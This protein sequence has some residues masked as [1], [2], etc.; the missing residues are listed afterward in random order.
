MGNKLVKILDCTLRDGGYCN[1]WDFGFDNTKYIIQKLVNAKIDIVECGFLSQKGNDVPGRTVFSNV[2]SLK[3]Y[4]PEHKNGSEYVCMINYGEFNIAEL[5]EN[6]GTIDGV[7]VAFHKDDMPGA[8]AMCAQIMEKGYDAYVQPMVTLSYSDFELLELV[9]A[10]NKMKAKALYIVDSF[11]VVR[12]KDL[13]RMYYLIDHNLHE[14][15]AIGYHSHNNM[16]LAYSNAQALVEIRT[17]RLNIIDSS[18]FGMGRGAGNL[19]TELFVEYVNDALQTDYKVFPLLQVIDNVLN[20]IYYSSYWGY[21]L[22]HYLSSKNNCHPNY[23][24]YLSDKNTLSIEAISEILGQIPMKNKINFSKTIIET[25]YLNYQQTFF[26]DKQTLAALEQQL[27]QKEVMIIAPGKSLDEY[28][29][30]IKQ[31]ITKDMIVFSVNFLPEQF[32]PDYIF[33]SNSKRYDQFINKNKYSGSNV[34]I[35][36][37]INDDLF[38]GKINYGSLRNNTEG[39]EDNATLLL[40]RLLIKTG[41]KSVKI[42]GFDGYAHSAVQNYVDKDMSINTSSEYIEILN[43]GIAAELCKLMQEIYIEFITPTKYD[44]KRTV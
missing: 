31:A 25:L 6:D 40:L 13:L 21:S 39:V 24:S 19:N 3:R 34:I 20:K 8:L 30:A 35:T 43:T 7:R 37:N 42:A 36:S 5:E 26:D 2:S 9:Q 1:N 17:S 32:H 15:I 14:D 44:C 12:R 41:A 16:Q 11:G 38:A 33:I 18:I 27:S 4:L 22:P 23:A 29:T 10:V 28:E